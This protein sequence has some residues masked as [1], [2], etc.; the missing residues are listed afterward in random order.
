[1]APEVSVEFGSVGRV[2]HCVFGSSSGERPAFITGRG[3]L[4]ASNRRG[5]ERCGCHY[6]K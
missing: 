6:A 2:S 5:S 4:S 3:R 1:L